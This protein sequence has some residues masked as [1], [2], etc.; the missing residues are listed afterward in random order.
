[1]KEHIK[2]G[3]LVRGLRHVDIYHDTRNQVGIVTQIHEPMMSCGMVNGVR[4][5][6]VHFENV[7]INLYREDFEL[8]E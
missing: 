5:F 8:V 2:V 1:M 3:S 4:M 6:R 7:D